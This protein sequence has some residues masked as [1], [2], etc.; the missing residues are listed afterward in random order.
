MISTL[1]PMLTPMAENRDQQ[2]RRMKPW[3]AWYNLKRW[4]D[5]RLSILLRDDFTCQLCGHLE[6]NTALLVCD[7]VDPHRGDPEKFWNGPFQTLCQECHVVHKQSQEQGGVAHAHPEWLRPSRVPLT[8]ICGPPASGKS[9]M[10]AERAGLFDV[11]IDL[12]L[13]AAE[14]SGGIGHEWSRD[15][16]LGPALRKR[17]AMLGYL[18]RSMRRKRAWFIVGEPKADRRQ[19][20]V[21]K[22]QPVEVIVRLVKPSDC[23]W[24]AAQDQDRDQIKTVDLIDQWWRD[25][26]PRNGDVVIDGQ[27]GG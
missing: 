19:W 16:W 24:F 22:L 13:I 5:L 6:N 10:V 15:D 21:D 27:G 4:K 1:P 20:W 26:S 8:L 14:M 2:A 9:K 3:K 23:K 12:D 17:N 18:S 25:Y 11:V 7:H